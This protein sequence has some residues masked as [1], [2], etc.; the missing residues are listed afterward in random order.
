MGRSSSDRSTIDRSRVVVAEMMWCVFVLSVTAPRRLPKLAPEPGTMCLRAFQCLERSLLPPNDPGAT[1]PVE[2]IE[3]SIDELS[4]YAKKP[5]I[6][7]LER[8]RSAA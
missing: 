3:G 6:R 7:H 2:V 1:P 5:R 4:L 8:F